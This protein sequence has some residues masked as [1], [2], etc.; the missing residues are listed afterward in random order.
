MEENTDN[1]DFKIYR[2]RQHCKTKMDRCISNRKEKFLKRIIVFLL[3]KILEAITKS[4]IAPLI[5]S[6]KSV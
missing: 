5:G 3:H 4:K 6:Y 1:R 2:Q